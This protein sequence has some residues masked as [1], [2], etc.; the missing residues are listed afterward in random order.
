MRLPK[1]V[2]PAAILSALAFAPA[3]ACDYSGHA[4]VTA[5]AGPTQSTATEQQAA[6]H[7]A[8]EQ[9]VTPKIGE[10]PSPEAVASTA[11]AGLAAGQPRAN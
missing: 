5:D 8:T 10:A 2:L 1:A 6:T 11:T 9:A 3:F 4:H 7:P